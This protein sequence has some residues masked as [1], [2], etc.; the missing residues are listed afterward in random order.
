MIE[1]KR[2]AVG[3]A[4]LLVSLKVSA[5]GVEKRLYGYAPPE[6]DS[7]EHQ[8]QVLQDEKAQYYVIW[9]DETPIGG[10]CTV[11]KAQGEYYISSLYIGEDWQNT[12]AGSEVLKQLFARYPN[13]VKWTLETPYKSVRNHHFYEKLGFVK[14]G[15]TEP[16]ADGFYL[17]LY[18]K[19]IPR[20][21]EEIVPA[22]T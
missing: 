17:F 19:N 3:D 10:T 4:E 1:L 11:E 9:Q 6:H 8:T 20:N 7:V 16:E 21:W 2:A 14:V 22:N 5:F 15:E 13:A 12:G 18:E